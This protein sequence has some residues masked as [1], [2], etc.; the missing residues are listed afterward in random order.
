MRTSTKKIFAILP[1]LLLAFSPDQRAP[2]EDYYRFHSLR[3]SVEP[4]QMR[5]IKVMN[6]GLQKPVIMEGVLLTY[7]NREARR[8]DLAGNFSGWKARRMERGNYGVW[9]YFIPGGEAPD[10]IRYKYIVDGLWTSDPRNPHRAYDGNGSYV[11]LFEI[12]PVHEGRFVT[13]RKL[14]RNLVEF[15]IFKPDARMIS[16]VGDFNNWNPENDLLE[17]GADG[18]WRLQKRLG[19]GTHRYK[20]IIDGRW[21]PDYN[22]SSSASDEMGSVCSLV[23][24][25]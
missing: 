16:L 14:D 1:L 23:R 3:D 18:I 2:L 15:R 7:R 11:S 13:Y 21:H 19:R 10:R 17:K 9:Y 12:S 5:V 8:V 25:Q 22:N 4:R 20:Y 6:A 24:I